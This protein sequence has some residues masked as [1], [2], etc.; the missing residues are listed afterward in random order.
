MYYIYRVILNDCSVL[1]NEKATF[2]VI[3]HGYLHKIFPERNLTT[4]RRK[5]NISSITKIVK[6]LFELLHFYK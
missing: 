3:S 6:F 4:L 1:S 2:I 5:K